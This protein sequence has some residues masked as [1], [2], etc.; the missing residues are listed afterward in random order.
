[1]EKNDS[2]K[3]KRFKMTIIRNCRTIIRNSR[4]RSF[5]VAKNSIVILNIA[6]YNEQLTLLNCHLRL[7]LSIELASLST[8]SVNQF[9][10]LKY[11]YRLQN[12]N[13]LANYYFIYTWLNILKHKIPLMPH[14]HRFPI[15]SFLWRELNRNI[16]IRP[17]QS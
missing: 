3:G 7:Y 11:F 6:V 15:K 17:Q 4:W 13:Q 10:S 16:Y 12:L 8:D 5:V 14:D 2:R 1:M 9:I